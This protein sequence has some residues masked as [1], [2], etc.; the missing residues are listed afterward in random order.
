MDV[1][2]STISYHSSQPWPFPRSLM[3]GFKVEAR[4]E[5][6]TVKKDELQDVKWFTKTYIKNRISENGVG[7]EEFN[8]PSKTA[9]ANRIIHQWIQ[10]S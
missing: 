5:N 8:I 3:I 7:D 4:S 1:D 9:M 10:S 2:L 6:I